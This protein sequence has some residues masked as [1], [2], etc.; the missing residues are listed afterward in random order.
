MKNDDQKCFVR[1]LVRNINPLKLH[2]E[3]ITQTNKK[4]ANNLN[5]DEIEFPVREKDFRKIETKINIYINLF[6]YENKLVFSI[7]FSNKELQNLMDFFLVTDENKS[8]Y[9]C[10]KDFDRF[11]FHKKKYKK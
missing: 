2:P 9:V 4:L 6:C 1:C 7:Y 8:H 10:I 11:M 3:R 5:Y